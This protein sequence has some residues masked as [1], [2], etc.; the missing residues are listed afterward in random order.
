[1]SRHC[2]RH[3]MLVAACLRVMHATNKHWTKRL[4]NVVSHTVPVGVLTSR[5]VR[6]CVSA[7]TA[8][9]MP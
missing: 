1:M 9:R 4:A 5:Y 2:G 8:C 7:P 6:A 3:P